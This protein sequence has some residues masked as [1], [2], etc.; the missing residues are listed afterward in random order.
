MRANPVVKPGKLC[1]AWGTANCH[2]HTKICTHRMESMCVPVGLGST[3]AESCKGKGSE[4]HDE[5]LLTNW[6]ARCARGGRQKS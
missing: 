5:H 4:R 3:L 1:Q 6:Q 2:L